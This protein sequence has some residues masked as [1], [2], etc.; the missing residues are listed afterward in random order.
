MAM[1]T[2]VFTITV[3][4]PELWESEA[5]TIVDDLLARRIGDYSFDYTVAY[6]GPQDNDIR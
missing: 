3:E 1:R 4:G 2:Y 6:E 5:V